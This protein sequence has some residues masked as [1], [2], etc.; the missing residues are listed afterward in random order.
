[1]CGITAYWATDSAPNPCVIETLLEYG[2]RRGTDSFGYSI[3]FESGH[4][5][6]ERKKKGLEATYT[7]V[8]CIT[9]KMRKGNI[10]LAC[11]RAIPETEEGI[12]NEQDTQPID[13][14]GISLIHNGSV[15][16]FIRRSLHCYSDYQYKTNIDSESIIHAYVSSGRNM[17]ATMEFLSGGFAFIMLDKERKKLIAVCTH[18]PLYCGYVKG[19]GLFFSSFNEAI[20]KSISI[21]KGS[22]IFRQNISL[23]EDFYAREIPENTIV[24]F[25]LESKMI[26]ETKFIPRYA[27]PVYDNEIYLKEKPHKSKVLIAASGGLDSTT[28]L[29]V[30][31]KSGYD[32][33]AVHFKYGHRGGDAENF[34]IEV[35]CDKLKI[36]LIKF[37]IKDNM[38]KLDRGGMLT[39]GT[40]KITTGTDGGLKTTIAWT[41]FRN[42]FFATYLGALAE[43]LI[44]NDGY[45]EVFITGGFMNL[46]ESGVYPDNSERFINSFIKFSRFAS[47]VGTRIK[48]L[49]CC[50]NLLKSEQY[51]LLQKM[52][53][54]EA[55]GPWLVSCDR[56]IVTN[57]KCDLG[58]VVANCSKDGKP[59]CGSGLLSYWAAKLAGIKDPRNYYEVDDEYVPHEHKTP[60][61]MKTLNLKDIIDRIEIDQINKRML[62][63]KIGEG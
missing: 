49:H 60:L 6:F 16:E 12:N 30:L 59:A 44:L 14:F 2:R 13:N 22:T 56:P 36:P 8:D 39:D 50:A 45:T 40:S 7:S 46:T 32:V 34:A 37:D 43:S 47:I 11:H 58:L 55:I 54:L 27:H 17:K 57:S 4:T 53:L 5:L 10:L 42:G 25:D 24:E 48:P 63:L 19:H 33:T 21:I 31:K 61:T 9:R 20:Y 52:G 62:R 3:Y 41:C 26:N 38:R 29:A 35:I 18:S 51:Y 28:T 15:S 23:W 1:V